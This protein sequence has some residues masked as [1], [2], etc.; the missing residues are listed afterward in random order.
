[1]SSFIIEPALIFLRIRKGPM[2]PDA[3]RFMIALAISVGIFILFKAKVLPGIWK[4]ITSVML[5]F[6]AIIGQFTAA[7]TWDR[8]Y[9]WCLAHAFIYCIVY[10]YL[11]KY[12]VNNRMFNP[13]AIDW[14]LENL[15]EEEELETN[16]ILAFIACLWFF[17]GLFFT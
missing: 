4:W 15:T 7:D 11:K 16:K 3:L 17:L 5:F 14:R 10:S 1:L 9:L 13:H 6:I 8:F 2:H 12:T